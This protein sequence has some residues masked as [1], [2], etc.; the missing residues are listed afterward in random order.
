[1]LGDQVDFDSLKSHIP[2]PNSTL[3]KSNQIT[4]DFK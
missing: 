2:I 4:E 3:P 1:M